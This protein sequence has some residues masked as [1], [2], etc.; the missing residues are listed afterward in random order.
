MCK[1]TVAATEQLFMVDGPLKT[2]FSSTGRIF[3]E[4]IATDIYNI[5]SQNQ[6]MN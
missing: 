2:V 4:D 5:Y 6:K 3:F 1:S